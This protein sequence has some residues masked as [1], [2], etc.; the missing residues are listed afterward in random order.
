MDDGGDYHRDMMG[1]GAGHHEMG[2]PDSGHHEMM[3]HGSGHHEMGGTGPSH[4]EMMVADFRRRFWVCLILTVPILLLA[5][6][7]QDVLH[8]GALAFPGDQYVLL[9]LSAFV[10]GWGGL[11]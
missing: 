7:I 6:L 5:P 2:G 8:L 3:E 10:Y 1:H 11:G 4:H 9:A